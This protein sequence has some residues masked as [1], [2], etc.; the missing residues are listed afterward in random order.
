VYSHTTHELYTL[1]FDALKTFA[2]RIYI[3]VSY[4]GFLPVPSSTINI[5]LR[6]IFPFLDVNAGLTR[7]EASTTYNLRLSGSAQF[8]IARNSYSL[9]YLPVRT[10][11][12]GFTL[13]PYIDANNNN[14]RD[15]GET[16]VTSGRVYVQN[17]TLGLSATPL[18]VN[19]FSTNRLPAYQ[20]FSISLDAQSL[21]DPM[22][23]PKYGTIGVTTES[24]YIK[25]IDIPIVYSGV[26]RGSVTDEAGLPL[27]GINI[28]L[29]PV[30][31]RGGETAKFAKRTSTFS[32]GEFEFIS[33]RPGDYTV[34][35]EP[36]Q[37]ATSGLHAVPDKR[38]VTLVAK[39]S[40]D[41]VDGVSFK[42]SK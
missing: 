7:T 39:P 11:F 8:D 35:V 42:L 5:S 25:D 6:Y 1:R 33:L 37:L 23:V 20:E 21:E 22:L 17:N 28:V 38:N 41:V 30:A 34:E 32:T 26:V 36:T 10:T 31:A 40:G 14:V 18:P 15:A 4:D 16:L 24:N 19:S 3:H 9:S 27:E 13:R 2:Q 29:T 12:G